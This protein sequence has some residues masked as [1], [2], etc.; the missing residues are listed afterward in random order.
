MHIYVIMH[1]KQCIQETH[2]TSES[3]LDQKV[4]LQNSEI[5]MLEAKFETLQKKFEQL[6]SIHRKRTSK[7]KKDSVGTLDDKVLI[8]TDDKATIVMY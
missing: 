2:T 1:V 6:R 8:V 3:L 4:A 5:L 7:K